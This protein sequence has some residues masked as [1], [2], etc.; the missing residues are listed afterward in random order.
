MTPLQKLEF[1]IGQL[2]LDSQKYSHIE[3]DY[4]LA[5][6]IIKSKINQTVNLYGMKHLG[7]LIVMNQQLQP[8]EYK[9]II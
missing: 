3:V 6:D 1:T 4:C 9:V 2:E 5:Y 7:A 8:N